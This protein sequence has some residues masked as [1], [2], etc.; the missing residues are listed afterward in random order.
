[1]AYSNYINGGGSFP[2]VVPTVPQTILSQTGSEAVENSK[3]ALFQDVFSG[4]VLTAFRKNLVTMGRW[5]TKTVAP[6]SESSSFRQVGKGKVRRHMSGQNVLLDETVKSERI[7]NQIDTGTLKLYLDR[8][9]MGVTTSDEWENARNQFDM[10]TEVADEIGKDL[11]ERVD[12]ERLLVC[13]KAA[14]GH[15]GTWTDQFVEDIPK[16]GQ[17][18]IEVNA[19]TDGSSLLDAIKRLSEAYDADKMMRGTRYLALNS[20]QYNLLV[21]NQDLLNQDFSGGRKNGVYAEGEVYK[22]WGITLLKTVELPQADYSTD[23]DYMNGVHGLTYNIDASNV[24]G[25]SWIDMAVASA[26]A[27]AISISDNY[28]DELQANLI[29]GK[30]SVGHAPIYPA[31]TGVIATAAIPA[32]P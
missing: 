17:E 28:H 23:T 29:I 8:P 3:I 12:F 1:M 31:G 15:L 13:V 27:N 6:N 11:A 24:A 14:G 20:P 10:R 5:M 7:M 2:G 26:E 30:T 18:I 21:Q 9:I 22:A 19:L 32:L 16:V 4:E 25:V